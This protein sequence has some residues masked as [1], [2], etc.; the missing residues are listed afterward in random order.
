[1]Y[2]YLFILFISPLKNY[3]VVEE[4]KLSLFELDITQGFPPTQ[5]VHSYYQE[6]VMKPGKLQISK[7]RSQDLC[8]RVHDCTQFFVLCSHHLAE[9]RNR[10]VSIG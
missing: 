10:H 8:W 9:L 3:N 2:F 6:L 5:I 1:M 7:Q 4:K